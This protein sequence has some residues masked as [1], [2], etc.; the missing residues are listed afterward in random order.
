RSATMLDRAGAVIVKLF[1]VVGGNVAAGECLFEVLEKSGIDRLYVFKSPV[2]RAVLD[3][4]DLTVALN[5]LRLDL[6]DFF[7]EQNLVRQLAVDDLLANFGH[8]TR[9]E[10]ISS[11]RPSKWR[12]GFL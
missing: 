11:T 2:L 1:V 7:V 4:Q 5:Y 6:P 10:R 8:A 3:H 9:A 12:F